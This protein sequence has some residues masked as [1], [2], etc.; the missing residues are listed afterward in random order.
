MVYLHADIPLGQLKKPLPINH[1][2]PHMHIKGSRNGINYV[3]PSP[4]GYQVILMYYRYPARRLTHY[5]FEIRRFGGASLLMKHTT[6]D[7]ER[8]TPGAEAPIVLLNFKYNP[9]SAPTALPV[10]HIHSFGFKSVDLAKAVL[11]VI[12]KMAI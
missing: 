6:W 9:P 5:R 8:W 1:L 12:H 4:L 11:I 10:C 2:H 7:L 3:F